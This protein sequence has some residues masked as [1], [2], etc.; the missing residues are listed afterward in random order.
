MREEEN[1][2]TGVAE[3]E[4]CMSVACEETSYVWASP[5]GIVGQAPVGS[6]PMDY[7]HQYGFLLPR[8]RKGDA[9]QPS[10]PLL[11][12]SKAADN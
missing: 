9:L 4:A 5:P 7:H 11:S 2:G 10:V 12:R 3:G 1:K 8:K 6:L